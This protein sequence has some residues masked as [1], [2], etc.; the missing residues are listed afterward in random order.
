MRVLS[1]Q[2]PRLSRHVSV[3]PWG[4]SSL[5]SS[6]LGKSQRMLKEVVIS[7]WL[8]KPISKLITEQTMFS[9]VK[10]QSLLFNLHKDIWHFFSHLRKNEVMLML[11]R[12]TQVL[13][14]PSFLFSRLPACTMCSFQ[15]ALM[16][17][18][19]LHFDGPSLLSQV[20]AYQWLAR[21]CYHMLL[22]SFGIITVFVRFILLAYCV[23][24]LVIQDRKGKTA[25]INSSVV[26]SVPWSLATVLTTDLVWNVTAATYKLCLTTKKYIYTYVFWCM[27]PA[28]IAILTKIQQP[29]FSAIYRLKDLTWSHK[30][31]SHV[32]VFASNLC[33]LQE[34]WKQW[35]HN[36]P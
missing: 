17:I 1:V 26:S 20:N 15:A 14:F 29:Q 18:S 33:A 36:F 24:L 13:S 25:P 10:S 7:V 4:R 35:Q 8:G 22:I 6:T 3:R 2:F 27:I 9:Y 23:S 30:P 34:R 5:L 32:Q 12:Y 21:C 16:M 19:I 31:C 11:H 28:S